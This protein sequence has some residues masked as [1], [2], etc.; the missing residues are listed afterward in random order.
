MT[1]C[2]TAATSRR[3]DDALAD[4]FPS[5]DPAALAEPAGDIRDVAGSARRRGGPPAGA[6]LCEMVRRPDGDR[7]SRVL[8]RAS[9]AHAQIAPVRPAGTGP[10]TLVNAEAAR[11]RE[12]LALTWRLAIG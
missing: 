2:K 6:S 5:G 1:T 3:L 10:L 8:R 12:S 4:G 9:D 7:R 11:N